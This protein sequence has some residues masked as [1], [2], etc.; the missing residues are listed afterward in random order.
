MPGPADRPEISVIVPTYNQSTLLRA[1]LRQLARQTL[2]ADSFEVI[3][4]DDGSADDTADVVK[5]FGDRLRIGLHHQ[6]DLGFRLATVRNAGA[7]LA[8]GRLL[9]FL[10]TGAIPGPD[11]LREHL[12]AHAAGDRRVVL[13]Y[14]YGYNPDAPP[15][16]VA[17]ML[18]A[19]HPEDAVARMGD[20]P[21]FRDVRHNALEACGFDPERR[22]IP[23][24]LCFTLNCSLDA[25]HFKAVGGFDEGFTDWGGEDLEI[26]YRLHRHGLVFHFSREAWVIEHPSER[27]V[28]AQL[29][30]W[31]ENMRRHLL[32][33]PDPVMEL[34][35]ALIGINRPF[36]DWDREYGGLLEVARAGRDLTVAGEIARALARV[37]TGDRVAVIG[38]GAELPGSRPLVA[39]DYDRELLDRALAAGPHLGHHAV[40]LR[41]PLADGAVDTVV[42]TSRLAALWPRWAPDLLMEAQRIGATVVRTFPLP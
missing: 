25:G 28:K 1:T 22:T 4:A 10:D 38:C 29:D 37:P 31:R 3:V 33:R 36:W 12:A 27:D 18:G 14:A 35:W 7:R 11:F 17:E 32:T 15:W 21:A 5:E 41:T 30:S 8:S 26:A 2:P 6:E 20:D 24:G 42:I 9:C 13:G 23:W 19:M 34:C 16:S 40:G 39:L